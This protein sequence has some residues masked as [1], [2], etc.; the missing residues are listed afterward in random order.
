MKNTLTHIQTSAERAL[1]LSVAAITLLS[2]LFL[3]LEPM[4]TRAVA[5]DVETFRIRQT[6]TDESSFLVPPVNVTMDG[7]LNGVTGGNA[8]GT[9]YFVVQSNNAAGYTV[10]IAFFNNGGPNAMIG[11]A[12]DSEAIRDYNEFG[13]GTD[14]T[15]AFTPSSSAQFGYTVYSSSTLDTAAAFLYDGGNL[16]NNGGTLKANVNTCYME[17]LTS[18]FTIV[19]TDAAAV[20]GATTT[21]QFRV[22]VPSG[23]VPVPTAETYTATATLSLFIK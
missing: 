2:I 9:T 21:L 11:D 15:F 12:T 18:G 6:I 14:P 8:T 16:C 10:E 17:P 13:A 3:M 1:V 7:S 20:T 19:D 4:V 5:S 23:A 22:N